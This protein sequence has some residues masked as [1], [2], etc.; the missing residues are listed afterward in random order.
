M[1]S[2]DGQAHKR[3]RRIDSLFALQLVAI[4]LGAP[5]AQLRNMSDLPIEA[6]VANSLFH[7]MW[8]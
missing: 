2:G 3:L 5:G 6:P 7:I 4:R 8:F 1:R